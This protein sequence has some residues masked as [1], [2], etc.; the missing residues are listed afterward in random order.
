MSKVTC[1]Y[2]DTLRGL[3]SKSD[4]F[5]RFNCEDWWYGDWEVSSFCLE[6]P[7]ILEYCDFLSGETLILP[8]NS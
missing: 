1:L 6:E 8:I 7:D 5:T 2:W 4:L 3:S